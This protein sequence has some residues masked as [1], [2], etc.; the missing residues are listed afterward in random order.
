MEKQ[1]EQWKKE[2]GQ[3]TILKKTVRMSDDDLAVGYFLHP[4]KHKNP[5]SIYSRVTTYLRQDKVIEAGSLMITECW[6]GGDERYLDKQTKAHLSVGRQL[7]DEL[8]FLE[9]ESETI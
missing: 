4:D 5:Y 8:G 2:H 7:V 6:L 1:L 9:V 3:G